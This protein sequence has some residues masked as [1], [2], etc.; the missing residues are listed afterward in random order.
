MPS[1][2]SSPPC[3]APTAASSQSSGG[4]RNSSVVP[5][6]ASTS[7]RTRTENPGTPPSALKRR[8]ARAK[9]SEVHAGPPDLNSTT[10]VQAPCRAQTSRAALTS[11]QARQSLAKASTASGKPSGSPRDFISAV[12][13]TEGAADVYS[14]GLEAEFC[15]PHECVEKPHVRSAHASAPKRSGD[16][17]LVPSIMQL[18]S[19]KCSAPKAW[20]S[21]A[22][23]S[24]AKN[25]RNVT[26]SS[27]SA[28]LTTA[29]LVCANR[30][31]NSGF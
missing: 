2:T 9:P 28:T 3:G 7:T 12:S 6:A 8:K 23:S 13:G 24:P 31:R 18:S 25:L 14:G 29:T 5:G 10:A 22:R 21:L 11:S 27:G 30:A 19:E 4:A 15:S 16:G 1:P 17:A 20:A 26:N